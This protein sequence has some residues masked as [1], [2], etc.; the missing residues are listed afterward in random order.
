[1]AITN[2]QGAFN[3]GRDIT[4]VLIG[5]FG[6]IDLA[7]I[8]SFTAKQETAM[9]KVDRLDGVQLMA[10]LP[11]GWS[12]T[13]EVERGNAAIDTFFTLLEASWI[14]GGV[15]TVSTLFQYVK[16]TNGSQSTF[17]YDNVGLKL[18]DAGDYKPDAA[19][20]QRLSFGANRRRPV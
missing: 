17:A 8:T 10:E 13:I 9:V 6:R 12:G 5:P 2:T 14:D 18:D 20:R 16:E 1:M 4:V 15:Y 11:K 19:V 3:T 7:N